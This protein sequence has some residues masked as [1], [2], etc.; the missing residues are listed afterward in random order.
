MGEDEILYLEGEFNDNYNS[1]CAIDSV[2]VPEI[3]ELRRSGKIEKDVLSTL[4][5]G[6][7][8]GA[9]I[10]FPEDQ[11][12][13]WFLFDAIPGLREYDA[14]CEESYKT[15]IDEAAYDMKKLFEIYNFAYDGRKPNIGSVLCDRSLSEKVIDIIAKEKIL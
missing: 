11:R 6:K 15:L 12:E 1:K 14:F 7:D 10:S 2:V 4:Y 5:L 13:N 3:A 9:V 8:F